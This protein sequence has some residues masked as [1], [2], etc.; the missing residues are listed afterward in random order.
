M[1]A[2]ST[3]IAVGEFLLEEAPELWDAFKNDRPAAEAW[4]RSRQNAI[5]ARVNFEAAREGE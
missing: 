1:D 4:L 2:I 3:F 5:E